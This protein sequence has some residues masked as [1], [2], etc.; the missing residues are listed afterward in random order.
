MTA[1]MDMMRYHISD[2]TIQQELG[3]FIRA[4][5]FKEKS[6]SVVCQTN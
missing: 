5:Y 1:S 3:K 2:D 6:P 4:S